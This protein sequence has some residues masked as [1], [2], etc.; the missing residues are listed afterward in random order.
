VIKIKIPS[1]FKRKVILRRYPAGSY[2]DGKWAEG[3]P[4]VDTEIRASVQPLEP[5]EYRLLPEGNSG[6]KAFKVFWNSGFQVGVDESIKTDE[7]LID[8]LLYRLQRPE[9]W[10]G[11]GYTAASFVE[12]RP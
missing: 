9:D 2:V 4:P 3:G 12:A 1:A 11:F 5:S 7:L 10:N 6:Y 8:G